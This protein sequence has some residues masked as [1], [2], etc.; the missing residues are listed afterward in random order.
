MGSFNRK[1]N[2][3]QNYWLIVIDVICVLLSYAIAYTIRYS[4]TQ[5]MGEMDFVL[6][7]LLVL[8]CVL[9]S[10]LLDWNH[11]IFKRGYFVE[12]IAIIKYTVSIAIFWG[13]AV[14][15]MR[16]GEAF[17]RLVFGMFAIFNVLFTYVA[18]IAFKKYLYHVY[19]K[20]DSSDKV[21]VVTTKAHVKSVF[22]DIK[23]AAEWSYD[24]IALALLDED[25]EE[26]EIDGVPVVAYGE[27]FLE[28]AKQ[29][30]MDAAFVYLPSWNHEEVEQ[31]I[32]AFETMGVVC[33]YSVGNLRHSKST[34]S[35]GSFAGHLVIT[36]EANV[37]DYR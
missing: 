9:Y 13:F 20:S 6:C 21:M 10:F 25:I 36:Y 3:I 18:H 7:L 5:R 12:L 8:F 30:M 32:D 28:E 34:Q 1:N 14:F 11:F 31:I 4:G 2:L 33:Y 37:I 27:N 35:V 19:K 23:E 17:S 16:Q 24:V 22:E 29:I 15:I 26:S